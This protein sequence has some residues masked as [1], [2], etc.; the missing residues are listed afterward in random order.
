MTRLD[1]LKSHEFYLIL[2]LCFLS[3]LIG[4]INPAFFSFANLFDLCKSSVVMGMMAL[5]VLFVMISGG[6]DISFTAIAVLSM[7]ASS[8]LLL[9][10]DYTG[11]VLLAFL[12]AGGIG[13]C[14]GLFNAFFIS[15]YSLP[16]LIV[17]LGTAGLFRG[18]MLAFIGTSII[19]NLPEG[20]IHFSK[21]TVWDTGLPDETSI[22]L[23]YT[24]VIFALA[25]G[26]TAFILR[27]TLIGRGI[28]AIG[29]NMEGARRVGFNCRSI[30]FFLYGYVGILSGMAGVVHACHMR[31]ADPF[32]IV[33][34]ELDVIAAVVL[35]GATLTGGYGSVL[36]TV[37][38]VFLLVIINNS[39]ILLNI[40]SYWQKVV[41]GLLIIISVA[42][43]AQRKKD[44]FKGIIG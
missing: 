28:Y 29:G 2:T 38:G 24:V 22:G 7:Y 25:I 14:L 5:G 30:Q 19:Y 34:M 44:T 16:T 8:K 37:L 26:L 42:I 3:L 6:I 27:N 21:L 43:S 39:L 35:G 17:T 4:F 40:P 10:F 11:S 36:G 32:D 15:Y 33:G 23:S 12:L 9:M 31:N 20:M 18:F 41:V 13:L 1:F